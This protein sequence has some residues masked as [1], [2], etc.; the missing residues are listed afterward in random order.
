MNKKYILLLS[1]SCFAVLISCLKSFDSQRGNFSTRNVLNYCNAFE[2]DDS[3]D[4][5][6]SLS[7]TIISVMKSYNCEVLIDN[8]TIDSLS[9]KNIYCR[10][11]PQKAKRL[12]LCCNYDKPREDSIF[13]A[14]EVAVLLEIARNISDS[15]SNNDCGVDIAFFDAD[16]VKYSA[17]TNRYNSNCAG[18]RLFCK[19]FVSTLKNKPQYGIF[20]YKPAIIGGILE[21]DNHSHY[22][23]AHLMKK[24]WYYGQ[25]LGY[26][27]YFSENIIKPVNNLG[28]VLSKEA[29][30]RTLTISCHNKSQSKETVKNLDTVLIK[31]TGDVILQAIFR[32][33]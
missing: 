24:I 21:K 7:D 5:F 17:A 12:L 30:I 14:A 25:Y 29:D 3:S 15:L 22:F 10:F 16:N 31:A 2:F 19:N 33:Y 11:Y 9:V 6:F 13:C 20:L 23:A 32:L 4:N 8:E 26:D 27:K 28:S 1:V 18:C